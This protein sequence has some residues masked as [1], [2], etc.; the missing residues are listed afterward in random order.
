MSGRSNKR[1]CSIPC[2]RKAERLARIRKQ[3]QRWQEHIDSLPPGD[4]Q[5]MLAAEAGRKWLEKNVPSV[6]EALRGLGWR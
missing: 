5:V 6:D 2:R 3:G 4:R 1:Y